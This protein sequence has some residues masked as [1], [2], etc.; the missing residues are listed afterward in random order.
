MR[1]IG[2]GAYLLGV[3]A[4][5]LEPE[6]WD[7]LGPELQAVALERHLYEREQGDKDG[8]QQAAGGKRRANP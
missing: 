7:A 6:E 3:P 8:K 4:R 5:D 2:G 1:Y